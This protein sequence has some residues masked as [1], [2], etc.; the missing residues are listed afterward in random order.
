MG[1][2]DVLMSVRAFVGVRCSISVEVSKD[3]RMTDDIISFDP[4]SGYLVLSVAK[5]ASYVEARTRARET[6][7]SGDVC[8]RCASSLHMCFILRGTCLQVS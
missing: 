3:Q 4:M 1:P 8:K 2:P 6:P 7:G 5:R